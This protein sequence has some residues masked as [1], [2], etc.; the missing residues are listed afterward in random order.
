M[1]MSAR[2]AKMWAAEVVGLLTHVDFERRVIFI[3]AQP[4]D[5]RAYIV[6]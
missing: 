2:H 5:W 3:S 6:R 4:K 1:A